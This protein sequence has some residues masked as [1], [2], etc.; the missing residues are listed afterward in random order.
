MGV[1]PSG[2]TPYRFHLTPWCDPPPEKHAGGG[3]EGG[4]GGGAGPVRGN[5]VTSS[6]LQNK[7]RSEC[8]RKNT[9]LQLKYI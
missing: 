6:L 3:G 2:R 7:K 1:K 8:Y 9:L 5:S 4:E